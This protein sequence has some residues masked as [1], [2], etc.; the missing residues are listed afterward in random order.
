MAKDSVLDQVLEEIKGLT[1]DYVKRKREK[2]RKKE[3][4]KK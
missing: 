4:Q 1:E 3:M 2:D